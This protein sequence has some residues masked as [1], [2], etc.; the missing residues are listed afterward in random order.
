MEK[1]QIPLISVLIKVIHKVVRKPYLRIVSV[2]VLERRQNTKMGSNLVA[3][4]LILCK[5]STAQRLMKSQ[6][7]S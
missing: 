2:S 1:E 6:S 5:T 4:K 7:F 3:A